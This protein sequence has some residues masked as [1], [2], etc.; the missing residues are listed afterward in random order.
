MIDIMREMHDY[1]GDSSKIRPSGGDCWKKPA[2]FDGLRHTERQAGAVCSRLALFDEYPNG[3][4]QY[5]STNVFT[6][7]KGYK[8]ACN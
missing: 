3:K 4:K 6:V 5:V 2:T 1:L 7:S 8:K